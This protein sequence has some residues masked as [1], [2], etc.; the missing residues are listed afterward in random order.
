MIYLRLIVTIHTI[1]LL[2]PDKRPAMSKHERN[3]A[4]PAAGLSCGLEGA[5]H[6]ASPFASRIL[7]LTGVQSLSQ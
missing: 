4:C 2:N 6:P 5:G 3:L 7:R 1:L